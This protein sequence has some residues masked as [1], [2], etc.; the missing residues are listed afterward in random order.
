MRGIF[1]MVATIDADGFSRIA[2]GDI[3]ARFERLMSSFAQAST[4]SERPTDQ[5]GAP[6]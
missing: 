2:D 1:P 5:G 6:A 3:R 4:P